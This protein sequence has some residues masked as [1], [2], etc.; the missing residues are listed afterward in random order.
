MKTIY[1]VIILIVLISVPLLLYAWL[2]LD[3]F[4]NQPVRN[5]VPDLENEDV[6]QTMIASDEEIEAMD[7]QSE[8]DSR[9]V[10][11]AEETMLALDSY[12]R[13]N[14]TLPNQLSELVPDY[15][16]QVY[17]DVTYKKISD[18]EAMVT[19]ELSSEETELM[20]DDDG[21][22]NT[23]YELMVEVFTE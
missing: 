2:G 23:L 16:D 21:D 18:T 13:D 20:S 14:R 1:W 6:V 4:Q 11:E 10:G 22:D 15:L 9:L 7:K 17:S 5:P 8:E 3:W 12:A 19:V